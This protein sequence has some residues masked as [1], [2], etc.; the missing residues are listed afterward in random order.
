[1]PRLIFARTMQVPQRALEIL[2]LAFVIDLLPLGKFES[3]EHFLHFIQ[4]MFQFLDDTVDLFDRIGNGWRFVRRL[5]VRSFF[6]RSFLTRPVFAL[7]FTGPLL[8]RSLFT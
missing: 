6:V 2:N 8:T 3:F 1:M 7:L 5:L 4:R